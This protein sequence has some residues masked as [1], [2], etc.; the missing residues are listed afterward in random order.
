M[1]RRALLATGSSALVAAVAGCTALGD[2]RDL[3]RESETVE[4]G[5]T[6]LVYTHG[7]ERLLVVSVRDRLPIGSAWTTVRVVLEQPTNTYLDDV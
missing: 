5:R 1:Q 4:A 6:D 2:E 7:G 3:G